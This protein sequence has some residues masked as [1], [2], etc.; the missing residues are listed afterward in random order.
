M[1]RKKRKIIIFLVLLAMI[2][3]GKGTKSVSTEKESEN[4]VKESGRKKRKEKK[5]ESSGEISEVKNMK[6]SSGS[7]AN[8]N[9]SQNNEKSKDKKSSET[10]KT[11]AKSDNGAEKSENSE[12]TTGGKE[13]KIINTK[14]EDN[15]GGESRRNSQTEKMEIIKE[16]AAEK[17]GKEKGKEK[18]KKKKVEAEE[19]EVEGISKYYG[20][21][22]KFIATKDGRILK[23][24]SENKV[25]PT[26]SLAKVMNIVVALDQVDKGNASLED[27]VCF[28]PDTAN[29]KG[30]WLNVK[31]G[32]CF[33]LQELLK[34]EIIYSANNAAY[35]VAKHIG[36]G[37]IDDFVS[38]MNEKA[39]ELGMHNTQF[40]TPAGLPTSMT[41]KKMDVS[42]AYD[43]YLLGKN[44]IEDERIKEWSSE[45]E[46]VLPN[47]KGEE[48]IYRNRNLLLYRH[49]I[50][51]LKTGF[52]ANAGY[53]LILT[54]RM[55]NIE[56]ISITLGNRTDEDRTKDQKKEFSM[57]EDRLK[58]V[59]AAGKEMGNFKISNAVKKEV[60]GVISENIY[61]ID[62][63]AYTFNIKDLNIDADNRGISK[64]DKIGELEVF[65][66]G[67]L[68]SVVDIV[69]EEDTHQ[70]SLF[71]KF[72]RII[73][74]GLV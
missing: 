66:E 19:K 68:L 41:G 65:N 61:Q 13:V 29:L 28:T 71:G 58:P 53:N 3:F 21:V 25:H 8:T 74:F 24:G 47:S 64:G 69:S 2:S 42:T 9:S 63:S 39:K 48:V 1:N 62:D 16:E 17:S 31:D 72:L 40:Y 70:L 49:G 33:K 27:S 11:E 20:E 52:H 54:S 44:A 22:H 23:H 46:L 55:G 10:E 4:T 73:T 34:A 14:I 60:K 6:S 15:Q 5:K 56:I 38:L 37:N 36:K 35:L 51:G 12:K 67:K 32:D 7:S 59:Y 43:M 30:S 50:Y 18:E 45:P 57:I 26:A